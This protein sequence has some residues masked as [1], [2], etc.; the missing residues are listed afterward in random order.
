MQRV[1]RLDPDRADYKLV[2]A[3]L[4]AVM[5]RLKISEAAE[6]GRYTEAL[7]LQEQLT[8]KVEADEIQASGKPGETTADELNSVAWHAVFAGEPAKAMA[9][10]ERSL[11]LR[12]GNLAVETNRAHALMYL[13]RADEARALYLAFKDKP[14]PDSDR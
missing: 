12:P 3:S 14:I 1:I 10:A 4:E 13:D 8:A 6:G 5:P 2:L 9:A 11:T 7:H